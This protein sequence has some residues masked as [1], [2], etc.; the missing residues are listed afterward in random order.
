LADAY[1]AMGTFA[2]SSQT[3]TQ[4]LVLAEAM[5]AG[6]PVVAIDAPGVREVVRDGV[7]GRLLATE[8]SAAF[9]AALADVSEPAARERLAEGVARTAADFSIDN[10]EQRALAVY[11]GLG[12]AARC[13][14]DGEESSWTVARRRLREEWLLLS[15]RAH[16]LR[17]AWAAPKA[18]P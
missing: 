4:G 5:A 6:V 16:T 12:R 8:D 10:T 18:N 14:V 17:N 9:V 1:N 3:E 2:F 13:R 15:H 11:S 7:N